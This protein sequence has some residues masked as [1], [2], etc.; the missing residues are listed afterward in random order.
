MYIL[1][2]YVVKMFKSLINNIWRLP[3]KNQVPLPSSCCLE[4]RGL[5]TGDVGV[6]PLLLLLRGNARV[7]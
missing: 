5:F 7:V 1:C 4:L 2:N 6:S 3:A